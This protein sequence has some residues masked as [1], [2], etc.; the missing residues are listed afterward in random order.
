MG[1]YYTLCHNT[2][3]FILQGLHEEGECRQLGFWDGK[4]ANIGDLFCTAP[5]VLKLHESHFWINDNYLAE[6]IPEGGHPPSTRVGAR[7]PASWA[8]WQPSG[9]HLLLYEVFYPEKKSEASLR[10]ETPPPR[11]GT[12]AEPI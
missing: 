5:K 2:Y 12:L 11:G 10:D 8:T 9:A 7:P 3:A 4:G 6:E 1:S